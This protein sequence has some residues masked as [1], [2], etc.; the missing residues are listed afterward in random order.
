LL[1]IFPIRY[2]KNLTFIISK[3]HINTKIQ[4]EP[5]MYLIPQ[6]DSA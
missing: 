4:K 6:D 3:E 1:L 2:S 5:A